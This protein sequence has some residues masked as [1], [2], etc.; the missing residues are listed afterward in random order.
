MRVGEPQ[1]VRVA[2]Y[3]TPKQQGLLRVLAASKG[4]SMSAMLKQLINE[5]IDQN[6][7]GK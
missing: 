1:D 7:R 6:L 3:L 2:A 5:A 4:L